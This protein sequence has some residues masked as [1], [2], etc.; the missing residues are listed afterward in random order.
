M[1]KLSKPWFKKSL[2]YNGHKIGMR[3]WIYRLKDYNLKCAYA[4]QILFKD[5]T[6]EFVKRFNRL[7]KDLKKKKYNF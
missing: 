7:D 6:E 5:I 3:T 2:Q 4:S 1:Q